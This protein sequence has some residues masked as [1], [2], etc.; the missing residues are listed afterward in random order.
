MGGKDSKGRM[1]KGT[2][3]FCGDEYV[4]YLNCTGEFSSCIQKSKPIILYTLN[5]YSLLY[6][7]TSIK[8][9]KSQKA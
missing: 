3:N 8:L 9:F 1:A 5:I 7:Y 2:R 4:Y 6:N